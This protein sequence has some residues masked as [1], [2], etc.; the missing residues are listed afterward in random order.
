[1]IELPNE[2]MSKHTTFRIGGP[3]ELML[4]P[5]SEQELIDAVVDCNNHDIPYRILGNGSNLLVSDDGLKGRVINNQDACTRLELVDGVVYAGSS[6]KL[7]S[8]I[9]FCVKNGLEGSEYLFSVPATIGGAVFMNAGRGKALNQQISDYL[10]SVRIFD[11]T[12]VVEIRKD[13]CDF[14]YRSSVFHR[15]RQWLILGAYFKPPLQ[16][17]AV[18]DAKV[19]ERMRYV[20]ITQD[21]NQRAAGSIFKSARHRFFDLVKGMKIG[22]AQYSK[23]TTN[24]INNTGSA[25]AVDVLRLIRIVKLLNLVTL[26]RAQQEIEVWE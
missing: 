18:G 6:V 24:W 11:G 3:V 25:K 12:S 21:F 5:G 9:R 17:V 20:K 23:K 7:Q 1:M 10:L 2:P 4:I 15:K 16:D 13:Q 26:K 14:A 8:F 19:K 22:D